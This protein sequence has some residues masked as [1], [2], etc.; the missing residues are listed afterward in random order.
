MLSRVSEEIAKLEHT[1]MRV[2]LAGKT[3][4]Y[5]AGILDHSRV[6][7]DHL[8]DC[9]PKFINYVMWRKD[10]N[11]H[12]GGFEVALFERPFRADQGRL[13]REVV[14][15]LWARANGNG[16]ASRESHAPPHNGAACCPSRAGC[17]GGYDMGSNSRLERHQRPLPWDAEMEEAPEQ[18][19]HMVLFIPCLVAHRRH[20]R[21][22]VNSKR[23]LN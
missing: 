1:A 12:K 13:L 3:L 21:R 18:P 2:D 14:E 10:A 22:L 17:A 9:L 7:A 16:Y 19:P 23:Q 5:L 6:T 11:A 20:R 8:K 4:R 15:D